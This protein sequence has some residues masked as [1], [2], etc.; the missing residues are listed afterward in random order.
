M[1]KNDIALNDKRNVRVNVRASENTRNICIDISNSLKISQADV[2][3]LSLNMLY[4]FISGMEFDYSNF[5]FQDEDIKDFRLFSLT[6][7]FNSYVNR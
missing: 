7:L 1:I 6:K 4:S 2:V 3:E 5:N